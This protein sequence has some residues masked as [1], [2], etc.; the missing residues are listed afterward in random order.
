MG[1][2]ALAGNVTSVASNLWTRLT[3]PEHATLRN[4]IVLLAAWEILGRLK[5]VAGGALPA[6]SSVLWRLWIDRADYP[7]H[8]LATLQGASAG[9][10]IGNLLAIAAG[11][12]FALFPLAARLFRGVNVALFALPPIALSPILVITFSGMTPRIILAAIACYF[13]TMTATVTGIS[14]TDKRTIDVVRA[15]GGGRWPTLRLVQAR[16]ALPSILAGLRI[17]APNAVLGSILAEFGGGGR[18][19]LGVYLIGSLGRAEPDRLWGIGLMATAMA[20]LAYAL[21]SVI[22]SRLTG[23]SRAVTVPASPPAS[24]AGSKFTAGEIAIVAASILL[25]FALWWLVLIAMGTPAMIAKNPV[26][27]FAYLFLAPNSVVTQAKLLAALA[28]TLPMTLIG[29]ALGLGFAFLLALSSVLYPAIIR[30]FMP[31]ALVTQTMPLVALTPLLVLML[32]R[33]PSVILWITVSVTFFPAFVTMAQGLSMVPHAALD[34]PR[35]YGASPLAQMRLVSIPASL[36]Y[37]FAATRLAVPRALLGVMIAE[38]LATGTGL[39]NLLNQSRGY[40]DY[41]MIWSVAVVSV[42][43]S[44]AFYQIVVAVETRV[45]ARRGMAP[46]Q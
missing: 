34:V 37:L 11:A 42:L 28:Q 9:F 20:G 24:A 30:G 36:P 23:S 45:L 5:L 29:M 38:W 6:P 3:G 1:T 35:A 27:L 10:L 39:G 16:S 32:G 33:G 17:A 8:I 25:P 22:A 18:H 19:G 44:V 12:V 14:Q 41:G 31:V 26:D 4:W 2:D 43:I 21:F 46:A 40:L 15:Y 13:I 7:D